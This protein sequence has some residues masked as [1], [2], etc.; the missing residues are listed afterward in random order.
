[1]TH[2]QEWSVETYFSPHE[3]KHHWKLKKEFMERN[4]DRYP[5]DQLVCLAQTLGNIE[6]MGCQ[7]PQD[8]MELIQELSMGLVDDFREAQR[9]KLQ[10]TFVSGSDAANKKVNRK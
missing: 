4:K 8:T 9:G 5:E 7:Y 1:M 3:P 2:N 6:F 10:R